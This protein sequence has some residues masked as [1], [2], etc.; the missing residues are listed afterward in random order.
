MPQDHPYPLDAEALVAARKALQD[1]A[2]AIKTITL[3]EPALLN[4][5][6]AGY[7]IAACWQTADAIFRALNVLG[8]YL[9]DDRANHALLPS[10]GGNPNAD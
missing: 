5:L 4:P 9:D 7:S 1:T 8:S 2:D 10:L 3:N 6:Y